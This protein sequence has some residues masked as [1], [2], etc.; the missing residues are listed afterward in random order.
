MRVALVEEE[1]AKERALLRR[2]LA[3]GE[4]DEMVSI[5]VLSLNRVEDTLRCL[6]AIARHTPFRHEIILVDNGSEPVQ[7][8]RLRE[9]VAGRENTRLVSL[10][11]NLGVGG[12]RNH[13]VTLARGGYVVF[14]DNDIEVG[15]RWLARLLEE[16]EGDPRVAACCCR[17]VFPDGTIQFN[18][19][20]TVIGAQRVRFNLIDTGRRADDLATLERHECDWVPGGATI[21]RR[22]VL[23][24]IPYDTAIE[25]AYEDNDWSIAA[26]RAGHRLVNAPLATVVHHH[27]N[28]SAAARRD[29]HYVSQRYGKERL[30]RT[31][32]R[33]HEKHGLFIDEEDLYR[34]IG[35]A[36]SAE[37]I[38]ATLAAG[39]TKA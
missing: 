39:R 26:R 27:M 34:Y 9:A 18:G 13:G 24:A 17:V 30:E 35:Y 21:F 1:R 20:S 5:V 3:A 25:G 36:G 37:F 6:E 12:G 4:C 33:F 16:I 2:R 38:E 14:L 15:D 28:F 31:L 7:L 19:G 23:A 8:A 29:A 10:G 11:R 22:S 32:R